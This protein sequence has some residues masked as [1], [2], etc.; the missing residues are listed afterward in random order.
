MWRLSAEHGQQ[1]G[2]ANHGDAQRGGFVELAAGGFAGDDVVGFFRD[3]AGNFAAGVFDQGGGLVAFERGQG[4]GEH[5]G[6][7]GDCG[8]QSA[9]CF[10]VAVA[11]GWMVGG[12]AVYKGDGLG[13]QSGVF[14]LAAPVLPVLRQGGV[15]LQG[16]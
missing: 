9:C 1:F 2:F 6:F 16:V 11:V 3:A 7:A 13:E 14:G 15:V 5:E 8:F 4:A 10:V 12:Q